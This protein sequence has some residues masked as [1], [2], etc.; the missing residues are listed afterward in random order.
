MRYSGAQSTPR[1]RQCYEN[2]EDC[3]VDSPIYKP[4]NTYEEN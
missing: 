2:Y 3:K 4:G 1:E